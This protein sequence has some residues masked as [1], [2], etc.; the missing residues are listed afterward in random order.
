LR[1]GI[2]TRPEIPKTVDT[3]RKVIKLLGKNEILLCRDLARKL[4]RK[5]SPPGEFSRV[6][7]V[8]AI[9]GDGTVLRTQRMAPGVP[10]LGINLGVRGFLAE[11]DPPEA[12]KAIRKL[13]RGELP[14]VRRDRLKTRVGRERLPDAVNDVVIAP[15]KLGKTISL[16]IEIDGEPAMEVVGDGVIVSTPTGSTAYARA[17]GG[18]IL[19][20]D[21]GSLLLVPLCPTAPRTSP[22]VLPPSRS[23]KVKLTAPGREALVIVDGEQKAKIRHGEGVEIS[24]SEKPATFFVWKGFYTK[25]REKLG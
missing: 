22:L 4:G 25:L 15:A 19:D 8:I 3:A 9:G 23:L 21:L 13:T 12:P 5:G 11:V 17:A 2:V 6:D 16:R 1:V 20:P 24:R 7:A 18:P 14:V 10:V